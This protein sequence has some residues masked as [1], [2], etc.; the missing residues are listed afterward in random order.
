[1]QIFVRD[2][3][4]RTQVFEVE[5]DTSVSEVLALFIDRRWPPEPG[6]PKSQPDKNVVRLRLSGTPGRTLEGSK[7]AVC[8]LM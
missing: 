5:A 3:S 6:N 4:S 7:R 8:S 2:W 1:M